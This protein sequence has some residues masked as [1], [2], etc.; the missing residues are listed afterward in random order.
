VRL[1]HGSFEPKHK[2]SDEFNENHPDCSKNSI[3]KKLKDFFVKDKRDEDPRQRYYANE[4]IL[5][6]LSSD[7]PGGLLNPELSEIASKRIEPLLVE[8]RA[9]QQKLEEVNLEKE[10]EKTERD[11]M[12]QEE[13][14]IRDLKKQQDKLAKEQLR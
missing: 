1:V 14:L 4:E 8:L 9:E 10:R 6:Q 5:V 7:F 11:L 2:I 13:Q 12:K 3:E